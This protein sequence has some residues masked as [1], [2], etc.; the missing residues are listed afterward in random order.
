M[1]GG[2][3]LKVKHMTTKNPRIVGYVTPENHAKLKEFM[4][5]RQL[6][7]SKAIDVI[8]GQF[9]GTA[10]A[11]LLEN[12]FGSTPEVLERLASV[13]ARLAELTSVEARLVALE[14][15]LRW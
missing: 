13:E 2:G 11:S 7:E 6:S 14:A 15:R 3:T 1:L 4:E 10:P 5:Q 9:F 8:L 12:T